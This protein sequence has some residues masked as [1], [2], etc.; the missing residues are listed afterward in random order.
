MQDAGDA[1][2]PNPKMAQALKIAKQQIGKP[3]VWAQASPRAGFDCS[4]LIEYAFEAAGIKTP[5]R[6]TTGPMAKMG[7]NVAW[8]NIQPGDWIVRRLR[9]SRATSSCTSGTARSSPPRRRARLSSTSP[10]PASPATPATR[11]A[12]ARRIVALAPVQLRAVRGEHGGGCP[13]LPRPV[14]WCPLRRLLARNSATV[15][16]VCVSTT[17]YSCSYVPAPGGLSP[18]TRDVE[19]R[20]S[21]N[22]IDSRMMSSDQQRLVLQAQARS[23]TEDVVPLEPGGLVPEPEIDGE[24]VHPLVQHLRSKLRVVGTVTPQMDVCR[25]GMTA[26]AWSASDT[27]RRGMSHPPRGLVRTLVLGVVS[28]GPGR[29]RVSA[30]PRISQPPSRPA[31]PT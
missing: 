23:T 4:G 15:S 12:L 30:R 2:A 31:R 1:G 8:K 16:V 14:S 5:G 26:P 28:L 25:A 27:H 22:S 11:P 3:Y 21:L 29:L 20:P 13:L 9:R 7:K 18:P 6:L 19:A 10:S 17:A 24:V